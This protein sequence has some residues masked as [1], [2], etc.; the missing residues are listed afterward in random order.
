MDRIM[1]I[2]VTLSIESMYCRFV[3]VINPSVEP[4]GCRTIRTLCVG[5]DDVALHNLQAGSRMVVFCE[6]S[7]KNSQVATG[8]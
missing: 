4:A 6:L 7:Q 1:M 8:T 3:Q 5:R 2:K